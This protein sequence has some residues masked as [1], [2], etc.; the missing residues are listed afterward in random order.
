MWFSEKL[1]I[2]GDSAVRN[3]VT[4]TSAGSHSSFRFLSWKINIASSVEGR[5]PCIHLHVHVSILSA[6][7]LHASMPTTL[8]DSMGSGRTI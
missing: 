1:F 3:C 8:V 5:R 4:Y 6:S 7:V 2:E